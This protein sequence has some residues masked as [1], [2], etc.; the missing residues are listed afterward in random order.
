MNNGRSVR[1]LRVDFFRGYAL[2]VVFSY[3]VA[4]NAFQ[5]VAPGTFGFSDT[6][7]LFVF[8]SGYVCG[9][10][11]TRR[12]ERD[13][14]WSAQHKALV[15][16]AQLYFSNV[17]MIGI[18]LFV[19]AMWGPPTSDPRLNRFFSGTWQATPVDTI[20]DVVALK[21]EP[22]Q[23]A[24]L[25][26][27]VLLLSILPAVIV[28]RRRWRHV[29]ISLSIFLYL[30]V[31]CFPTW[32]RLPDPWDAEWFFNPFAWQFLFLWGAEM[33]ARRLWYARTGRLR[34]SLVLVAA[35]GLE[36]AFIVKTMLSP[37]GLG[38]WDDK[39]ILGPLRLWHF[40]CLLTVA[41]FLFPPGS[42]WPSSRMARPLVVCGQN[43]LAT[44]C[45]GGMLAIAAESVLSRWNHA[46]YVQMIVNVAGW[47]GCWL[48]AVG[49]GNIRE[50][51]F[52]LRPV[53]E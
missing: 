39:A 49:W 33:G 42:R 43:S 16:G 52:P 45:G 51:R 41:R 8:L 5:Q 15:R 29:A 3:H 25:P 53:P 35:I 4:G 48:I 21:V 32:V 27:Y 37:D 11:Y 38:A 12:I 31:Q 6:A 34:I 30:A 28:L 50:T 22:P 20:I 47:I 19:G 18:V 2:L 1:D 24:V 7:E 13:G 40:W 23:F 14:Y 26:L 44:Y 9:R 17:V 10:A 46:W 36:T